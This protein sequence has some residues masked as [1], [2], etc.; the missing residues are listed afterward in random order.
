MESV[1]DTLGPRPRAS[2]GA[3]SLLPRLAR[4]FGA[5]LLVLCAAGACLLPAR[6]ALALDPG[7]SL[8]DYRHDTWR[9]RDGAPGNI[10]SIAQT[11][12]GW[13]W[14]GTF[15]G[16]YRFDGLSFERFQP[17]SGRRL[18]APRISTLAAGGNG[19]LL[20]G[21]LEGGIDIVRGGE[22]LPMPGAATMPP[23]PVYDIAADVDGAVWIGTSRGVLRVAGG[24]WQAAAADWNLPAA[25]AEEFT[26]DQYRQLWALVGGAWY[27]L[28]RERRRF[29]AVA[30][31]PGKGTFFSPDGQMWQRRGHLIER[32]DSGRAGPPLP[33]DE[34]TR[35]YYR[36]LDDM[37]DADGN[38]W[39][40]RGPGSVARVRRQD[41]PRA[42]S[43]DP[44][45]LPAERLDQSW[46]LSGMVATGLLEDREG[47]VWVT[48]RN[49]LERFRNQNIRT[50][51]VPQGADLVT[52]AADATGA[53][54]AGAQHMDGLWAVSAGAPPPPIV[55]EARRIAVLGRD[56]ALVTNTPDA[57]ERRLPGRVER[58]GLPPQCAAAGRF[59][60]NRLL[61]DRDSTWLAM[62]PCGTF[63]Y[64]DRAWRS[65]KE[66]GVPP[67]IQFS[68][69]DRAGAIWFAYQ[70]G[71]AWRF[72]GGR[73]HKVASAGVGFLR[74]IDAQQEVLVSGSAG[75]AVLKDGRFERLRTRDPD[76]LNNVGGVMITTDGDRW[77]H[78]DAGLVRIRAADWR[79]AVADPRIALPAEIFDSSDGYPGARMP[80][81]PLA[82]GAID[83]AG[84]LWIS[85]T[86]GIGVLDP[87][88]LYR[89]PV[90]PALQITG[91]AAGGRRF[92]PAA[93]L[94][95]P[96]SS[97]RVEILFA[98]L[99]LGMPE[100]LQVLYRLEG[101]DA[102]WQRAGAMRRAI[103]ANL[104]PGRYRFMLKAANA[105]GV[106]NEEGAALDFVV[107]PRFFQTGWFYL[108]CAAG[109]AALAYLL[110][111]LRLRQVV[112]RVN[113][114]LG[115]RLLE[116]E[117]IAR[118]LHD[119]LLQSVQGLMWR[120]AGLVY[121]LPEDSPTR[122]RM[123]ELLAQG[124]SVIVEGRNAVL[125]LRVAAVQGEDIERA[126][127]NLGERLEKE[128]GAA[129]A[130]R[131]Q[132]RVRP[133]DGAVWEELFHIGHE[134]L[135]NAYR[136]AR[137]RHVALRLDFGRAAFSMA[138]RDDGAGIPARVLR[139]GFSEGHWGL[140]GMR[141]RAQLVD[142]S[143]ELRSAPGA[144]E[145]RV[146]IP[147]L[148]A[149]VAG[150]APGRRLR[151]RAWLRRLLSRMA[152]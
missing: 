138:V 13:L 97:G 100:R 55:P 114:A 28:D 88:R 149:Y 122:R 119:N 6:E 71:E 147:A 1:T 131:I 47:N 8:H 19:D 118:A 140:V 90:P 3:A 123:R 58:L 150:A 2:H 139:H 146:C 9:R 34:R 29:V 7:V 137:A 79:A 11:T 74:F 87:R 136:H 143:L 64:V 145:I 46:Q 52:L 109:V 44:S 142:G 4:A 125:G 72:A 22:L 83:H 112:G 20:V 56:G 81:V 27:K 39:L 86:E 76:V 59:S 17:P 151:L 49:G 78:A 129:F 92:A 77:L 124:E 85:G 16:L 60:V 98:A 110:Y 84:R 75:T 23:D 126:L 65:V 117:R 99:S 102:D 53:I 106:W 73:V 54:W 57:I 95:L 18:R 82:N 133:L 62:S 63:R 93:G 111:L 116:R 144:T 128:Y 37:F 32:L 103:Y 66:Y 35:H 15:D 43:F 48:T 10:S 45:T 25:R 21:Y 41:I 94:R 120:F 152:R 36:Q 51:A 38:L 42:G 101:V 69:V 24:A 148:R 127:R 26:L 91:L 141:E 31:P 105:N 12:D 121:E 5:L 50:V 134:A 108:L 89:N 30:R 96:P 61:E 104:A 67:R 115:A 68:A 33:R 113:A 107:A 40:L 14:I 130:L 70:N 80:Y 132:G 135:H